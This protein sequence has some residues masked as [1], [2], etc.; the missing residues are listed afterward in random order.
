M[1]LSHRIENNICI[2]EIEGEIE[3]NYAT[4]M[5]SYSM[6]LLGVPDQK[7]LILNCEK[8]PYIDSSGLGVIIYLH[9][10]AKKKQTGF[11][12]CCFDNIVKVIFEAVGL[13]EHIATYD[14]EEEAVES[15]NL[16]EQEET[17]G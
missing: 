6:P 9:Q 10:T 15:F 4:K 5:E 3:K 8:M 1:K 16:D 14:T 7:A 17:E 2:V 12:L 13:F 11:A